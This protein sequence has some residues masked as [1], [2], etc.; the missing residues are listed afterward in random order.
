MPYGGNTR[1]SEELEDFSILVEHFSTG[2]SISE[3]VTDLDQPSRLQRFE[4]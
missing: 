2:G 1:I 3:I 4:P